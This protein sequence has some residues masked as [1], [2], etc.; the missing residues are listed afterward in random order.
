MSDATPG[1]HHE[2]PLRE[3]LALF[4]WAALLAPLGVFLHE[5]GHFAIARALGY[6]DVI[7]RAASV[8]GGARLGE[9]PA[10]EVAAQAAGGPLITLLLIAIAWPFLRRR[11]A[12]NWAIAMA[13]TAPLR[14]LVGGVYLGFTV[15]LLVTG[16]ERGTPNFDEYNLAR[17]L[18]LPLEPLLLAE[19]LLLIVWWRIV[20][21]SLAGRRWSGIAALCCGALIG[22][23]AWLQLIGPR[24]LG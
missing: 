3:V 23:F 21:T 10:L 22:L 9:A 11:P 13:A 24:L 2:R 16:R 12:P 5:L 20:R 15:V 14:F 4:G 18:G 7:L 1:R 17:G 19:L 6:D 8:A